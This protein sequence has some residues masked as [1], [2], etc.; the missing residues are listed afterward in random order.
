[1]ARVEYELRNIPR[2]R[3]REYWIEA[4]GTLTDDLSAE[5]AGWKIRL[6]PMQPAVVGPL[7]IRRDKLIIEGE[8]GAVQ[9]MADFMRSKTMRGGG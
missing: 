2:H 1:M 9:K 3:M 4:G 8:Q 5:G 6:E 7:E